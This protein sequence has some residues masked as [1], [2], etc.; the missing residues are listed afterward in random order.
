MNKKLT[1]FPTLDVV[2]ADFRKAAILTRYRRAITD[3]RLDQMHGRVLR[4]LEEMFSRGELDKRA[5]DLAG[6]EAER[7]YGAR[8][9]EFDNPTA[10]LLEQRAKQLTTTPVKPVA[11]VIS[12]VASQPAKDEVPARKVLSIPQQ[13]KHRAVNLSKPMAANVKPAVAAPAS[14]PIRGMSSG[15]SWAAA[16]AEMKRLLNQM[17]QA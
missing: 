17:H 13:R 1:P 12:P 8:Q 9:E 2:P 3:E 16:E 7:A 11:K 14:R 15:S 6:I 4:D 10:T 5:F